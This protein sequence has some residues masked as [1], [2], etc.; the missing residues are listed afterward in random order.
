MIA[1]GSMEELS[2]TNTKRVI[3]HGNIIFD[4][5]PDTRDVKETVDGGISFLYSGNINELLHI[6]SQQ[7]I[8]DLSISEPDLEEIFF[9]YYTE[10]R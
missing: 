7:P 9:D 4:T 6:L 3:V 2:K 10:G 8:S 5:I 1:S